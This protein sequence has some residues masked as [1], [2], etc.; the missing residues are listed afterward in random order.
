MT[1]TLLH[2]ESE[3][4]IEEC[5]GMNSWIALASALLAP[6]LLGIIAYY[7]AL[8]PGAQVI[9]VIASVTVASVGLWMFFK[10]YFSRGLR[11]E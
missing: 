3:G 9:P 4:T 6:T 11:A 7:T 10:N 2:A 1:K 8:L 5:C